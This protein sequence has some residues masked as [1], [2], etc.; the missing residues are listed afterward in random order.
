M[1]GGGQW[2]GL[3]FALRMGMTDRFPVIQRLRSGGSA[4]Q[5]GCIFVGN[6]I[7]SIDGR[8]MDGIPLSEILRLLGEGDWGTSIN[9]GILRLKGSRGA[10][11]DQNI[12]T[13]VALRR[14]L[15]QTSSLISP[16]SALYPNKSTNNSI[17][18][19]GEAHE[20]NRV[21]IEYTGP[22]RIIVLQRTYDAKRTRVGVGMILQRLLSS[23]QMLVVGMPESGVSAESGQVFIGDVLHQIDNVPTSGKSLEDV[24]KMIQGLPGTA[25]V[26]M[27]QS[28]TRQKE[29]MEAAS[30]TNL[31]SFRHSD[32]NKSTNYV[33]QVALRRKRPSP[34][35]TAPFRT[36]SDGTP[37]GALGIALEHAPDQGIFI[38][39]LVENGSAA[40]SGQLESG[41]RLMAVDGVDVT[42][43][44]LPEIYQMLSGRIN[45]E[46]I[47]ACRHAD[48]D[49]LLDPSPDEPIFDDIP[50][51]TDIPCEGAM[52][53]LR[54]HPLSPMDYPES[55]SFRGLA[56]SE[57]PVSLFHTPLPN[58]NVKSTAHVVSTQIPASNVDHSFSPVIRPTPPPPSNPLPPLDYPQTIHAILNPRFDLMS[59][60]TSPVNMI[61]YASPFVTTPSIESVMQRENPTLP[62]VDYLESTPKMKSYVHGAG[63]ASLSV[64]VLGVS[65]LTDTTHGDRIVRFLLCI[66]C[67]FACPCIKDWWCR[68]PSS[69][70]HSNEGLN[71]LERAYTQSKEP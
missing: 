61:T 69:D 37:A 11:Q 17:A 63:G 71:S 41:S 25:V 36:M 13:I 23:G 16:V 21:E 39:H 43:R 35:E 62:T 30:H 70:A 12:T 18:L 27:L 20:Q 47:I 24:D 32:T 40:L 45:T 28:T 29:A 8:S 22:C 19:P 3:G 59:Y 44:G 64:L 2:S 7:I 55:P 4:E 60:P 26:L 50:D 10:L 54:Q 1:E 53:P 38:S 46:V 67:S 68:W 57:E 42:G 49:M 52:E 33:Q 66:V 15:G 5:S 65:D 56:A 14:G 6:L 31:Y 48:A 58:R 34:A 9:V 51:H